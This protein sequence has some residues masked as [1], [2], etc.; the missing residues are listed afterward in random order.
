[1][2]SNQRAVVEVDLTVGQRRPREL[3][4]VVDHRPEVR[5]AALGR[6]APRGLP[7]EPEPLLL[8]APAVGEIARDLGEADELAARDR[9]AR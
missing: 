5:E 8:C 2:N 6:L 7:G 9:A 1:M 3:R 4:Q